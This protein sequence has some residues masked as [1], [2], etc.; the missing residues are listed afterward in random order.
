MR[1][2]CLGDSITGAS[3]RAASVKFSDILELL[4]KARPGSSR[5]TV[6]NRGVGGDTT[7]DV[8]ARLDRDVVSERPDLVVLLIGYNDSL[9][10][11]TISLAD[12]EKNLDE[13][14]RRLHEAS[15]EILLLQYHPCLPNPAAPAEAWAVS[16]EDSSR[17]VIAR[18]AMQ[19]DLPVL[20]MTPPFEAALQTHRRE[21]LVHARDGIHLA[22][23]GELIYAWEIH[24]AI[25]G[26]IA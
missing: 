7:A 18:V 16:Q 1:I 9:R 19:H 23:G 26:V 10:R 4:L 12:T 2:V 22:P 11:G 20:D 25:E 13:I 6:L 21:E 3:N 15:I 14:V 5:A 24:R 17:P 8:L